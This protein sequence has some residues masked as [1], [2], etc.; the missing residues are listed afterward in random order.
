MCKYS[1]L[2]ISSKNAA[3]NFFARYYLIISESNS[4]KNQPD[5]T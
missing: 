4:E 5:N 3:I 2:N 1:R